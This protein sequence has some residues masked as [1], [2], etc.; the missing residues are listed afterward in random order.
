M[1]RELPKD[2][3]KWPDAINAALRE[4]CRRLRAE[5]RKLWIAVAV[6]GIAGTIM[7]LQLVL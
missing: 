4:E 1:I 3:A 7:W 5:N 6:L 2:R